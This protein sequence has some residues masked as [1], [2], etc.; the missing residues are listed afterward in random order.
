MSQSTVSNST[1]LL[2]ESDKDTTNSTISQVVK[3]TISQLNETYDQYGNVTLHS[4]MVFNDD[5][6]V[7]FYVIIGLLSMLILFYI[8]KT[9][10]WLS[11]LQLHSSF[12]NIPQ[13]EM[14]NGGT[15]EPLRS[16][17]FA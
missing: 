6:H 4:I 15:D 7:N 17:N 13:E 16:V 3:S 8:L 2:E 1:T 9:S 11:K 10:T 12:A 14:A 5:V